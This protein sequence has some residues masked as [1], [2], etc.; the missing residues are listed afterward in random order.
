MLIEGVTKE[1]ATRV[2]SLILPTRLLSHSVCAIV[3]DNSLQQ[4]AGIVNSGSN[5]SVST[6]CSPGMLKKK[7]QHTFQEVSVV[8]EFYTSYFSV[9]VL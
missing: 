1:Y 4:H 7:T 3:S 8:K 2:N 5:K 9:G 6:S